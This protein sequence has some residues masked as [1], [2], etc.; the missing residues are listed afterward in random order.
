MRYIVS[1]SS[2]RVFEH[3]AIFRALYE[4]NIAYYTIL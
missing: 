2:A 4:H 3:L 1:L